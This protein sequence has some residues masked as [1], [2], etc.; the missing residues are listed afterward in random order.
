M[1]FSLTAW[2][3]ARLRSMAALRAAAAFCS[4]LI[5]MPIVGGVCGRC[6]CVVYCV[7]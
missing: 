3:A 4:A 5:Q 2:S 1:V 6:V 7:V